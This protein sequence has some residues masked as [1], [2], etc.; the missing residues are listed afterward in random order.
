MLTLPHFSAALRLGLAV[1]FL[2]LAPTTYAQVVAVDGGTGE[3]VIVTESFFNGTEIV[4]VDDFFGSDADVMGPIVDLAIDRH[5]EEHFQLEKKLTREGWYEN[6]CAAAASDLVDRSNSQGLL[7]SGWE[8][9]QVGTLGSLTTWENA[10]AA[11]FNEVVNWWA[12]GTF[13]ST[14]FDALNPPSYAHSLSVVRSPDGNYYTVDNWSGGVKV[15]RV[16]PIDDEA[17]YFSENPDETALTEAGYRLSGLDERGRPWETPQQGDPPEEDPAEI[18]SEPPP[19]SEPV[20]VEVLTSA[21]PNDKLGLLG[22]GA[23]R[24]ITPEEPL[25][26]LIRFENMPDASAPAQEVLIRD[27]LDTR[28]LDLSTFE[29]GEFSFGDRRVPVPPGRKAFSTRVLLDDDRFEVLITAALAEA[30]GIV[31]WRFTTLDRSTGDLPFDPLDGFLPPNQLPP[32]G[33]GSVAFSVQ[34]RDDLPSGTEIRNQARIFFDLNEPIDTLPWVNVLD[35]APPASAVTELDDTQSG[36][37]FTVRWAGTDA[38]SGVRQYDVYVSINGGS[39]YRWLGNTFEPEET[40]V[41]EDGSTYAFFSIAYD[42]TGNAEPLKTVA[43]ASTTVAVAAENDPS[44]PERVTLTQPYPNPASS[45]MTVP[46]GLPSA[47]TAEIEVF[48]LLGRRVVQLATGD[49]AAGWHTLQWDV[50]RLASGV[51]V[52]RLRADGVSETRRVT[53]VR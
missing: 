6:S 13:S 32:E 4:P 5:P 28:V 48:D 27:T 7:P 3:Q 29:L 24:F 36:E 37:A 31:T 2:A 8:I 42:A 34:M 46:F 15:K 30:T 47:G 10:A 26:Y 53:V 39:F 9:R 20:D 16:Y 14:D 35:T 11:E 50:S 33:E 17:T 19:T 22:V 40:F 49:Q 1:L 43:D 51:Y 44:L 52:L 25:P 38:E 45:A 21:D 18:T 23:A 12:N 41:G